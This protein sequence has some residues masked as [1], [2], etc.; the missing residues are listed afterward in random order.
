MIEAAHNNNQSNMA[1]ARVRSA[2]AGAATLTF[3]I[4][5]LAAHAGFAQRGSDEV[6]VAPLGEAGADASLTQLEDQLRRYADRFVTRIAQTTNQLRNSAETPQQRL[7]MLQWK[8]VSLSTMVELA[9]GQNVVTSLFDM[10]VVT[11]LTRIMLEDFY[12]PEIFGEDRG[13]PLLESYRILEEDIWQIADQVLTEEQQDSLHSLILDW[14]RQN[15]DQIYPWYV[16][17]DEF[18]GQRAADLR[19]VEASGGLLGLRAARQSIDEV[20]AFGE[21]MMFYMQR[22][23]LLLSFSLEESVARILQAQE[24]TA[25]IEDTER[26]TTAAEE[27]VEVVAQLPY[28]QFAAIDQLMQRLS[29]QRSEFVSDLEGYGPQTEAVLVELRQSLQT[30]ERIMLLVGVDDEPADGQ[31]FDINDY[32]SLAIEA[33]EAG[34]ELRLVLESAE[35]LLGST[36]WADRELQTSGAFAR[37]EAAQ[38]ALIDR[39][40]VA[41]AVVIAFFFLALLVYRVVA[42]RVLGN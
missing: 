33:A 16:R 36:A 6:L 9:I 19:A 7:A 30:L 39:L 29:E 2:S 12:L 35:R 24:V 8:T 27:L 31:G 32:T 13:T 38:A 41:A 1:A 20:Q 42:A 40:A 34:R 28:D 10:L 11:T 5:L 25:V 14:R 23:P 37:V 18:S 22:A 3:C 17:L 4:A 15:P 21:R 26:F